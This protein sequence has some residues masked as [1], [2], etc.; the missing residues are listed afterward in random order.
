MNESYLLPDNPGPKS[1]QLRLAHL[2]TRQHGP[3]RRLHLTPAQVREAH[4]AGPDD[5]YDFVFRVLE[6]R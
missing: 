4:A 5:E 3:F 1:L 2:I 6:R